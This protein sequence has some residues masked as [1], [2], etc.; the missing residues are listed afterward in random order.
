M[1]V[2]PATREG[3]KKPSQEKGRQRGKKKNHQLTPLRQYPAIYLK[4]YSSRSVVFPARCA[5]AHILLVSV[6]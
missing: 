6:V 1:G 5:R 2:A 4:K 3:K